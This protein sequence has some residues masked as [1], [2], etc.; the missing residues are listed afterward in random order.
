[1]FMRRI[2]LAPISLIWLLVTEIRNRLFDWGILESYRI[3]KKSICI[4]NLS[5]GGTGK[6]PMTSYLA[7]MFYSAN[8][9]QILSRGYGRKSKGFLNVSISQTSENTGD[10]PLFYKLKFKEN[11][12]VAVCEKRKDGI[13]QIGIN[14]FDFR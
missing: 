5:V 8:K 14:N 11:V 3:Q 6:T 10:E 12:Q 13:E 1:M 7:E 2:L 4:G 9:V